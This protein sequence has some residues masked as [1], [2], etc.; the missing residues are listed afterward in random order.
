MGVVMWK[1]E[2]TVAVQSSRQI[3]WQWWTNV[4]KWPQWDTD[5]SEA[6][7]LGELAVGAQGR[8]KVADDALVSFIVSELIP[9]EKLAIQIA[10]FGATITYTYTMTEDESG[11]KIIHGATISGI[12]GLVWRMMLKNKI[13]TVLDAA[14]DSFALQVAEEAARQAAEAARVAQEA[15]AAENPIAAPAQAAESAASVDKPALE[16]QSHEVVGDAVENEL[17]AQDIHTQ[18]E[19]AAQAVIPEKPAVEEA[20][21]KPEQDTATQVALLELPKPAADEV[22]KK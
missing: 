4:E 22:E 10:L 2:R 18:I 13:I 1:Y 14:Q 7:V 15:A 20:E 16:K 11:L 8:M 9:E 5:L 21:R 12:F 3:V 17:R 6:A 19:V